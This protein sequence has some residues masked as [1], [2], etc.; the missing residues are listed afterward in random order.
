MNF[1]KFTLKHPTLVTL[2]PAVAVWGIITA[3]TYSDRI[4]PFSNG[5]IAMAVMFLVSIAFR[6]YNE[7]FMK[8]A[9]RSLYEDC[10]PYPMIEELKL[11]E[12]CAGRRFNRSGLTMTHAMMLAFAGEYERAE[13]ML[14]SVEGGD[15]TPELKISVRYNLATLYCLMNLR[16]DAVEYY[17]EAMAEAAKFPEHV[18]ERMKFDRLTEAEIECYRGNCER[19]EEIAEQVDESTK[20]RAVMR[21]YTLAK[22]HYIKGAK[23]EAA[24]EFEWVASNGGRLACAAESEEIAETIRKML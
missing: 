5:L 4:R 19:A 24:I 12:E 1:R 22:I 21:K 11:Y 9:E 20:L 3:F 10:D 23:S 6:K 17:D 14:R 2:V 18:R 8:K 13:E 7:T 16:R 15:Q